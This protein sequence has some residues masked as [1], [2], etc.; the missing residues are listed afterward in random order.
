MPSPVRRVTRQQP[1]VEQV[2][3]R[4]GSKPPQIEPGPHRR[5]ERREAEQREA[6]PAG[7]R[8]RPQRR[9]GDDRERPFRADEQLRQVE[10]R[11]GSARRGASSRS[12]RS[13][14]RGR[15]AAI[16]SRFAAEQLARRLRADLV[17]FVLRHRV[18]V[19]RLL[20]PTKS[21][22]SRRPTPPPGRRRGRGCSRGGT[23][24]RRRRWSR[25]CRRRCRSR[26]WPG[27]GRTAGRPSPARRSAR[28]TSRPARPSPCRRRPR[29]C[30]GSFTLRSRTTA[31]PRPRRR[32]RCRRRAG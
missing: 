4:P 23:R 6:R 2:A 14:V 26:R 25:P 21:A 30:R 10:R 11:P 19:S 15:C 24:C 12:G 13:G 3:R 28:R 22:S 5:V 27:P 32:A 17:R 9:R 31:G 20:V 29:E 1:A 18:S 16:S 7:Q 8:H